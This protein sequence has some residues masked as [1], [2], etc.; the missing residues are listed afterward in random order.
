MLR[1]KRK[2]T[3]FV[4]AGH[5]DEIDK[6]DELLKLTRDAKTVR[7]QLEPT[8]IK[9]LSSLCRLTV[10]E[11][12]DAVD[13]FINQETDSW[14]ELRMIDMIKGTEAAVIKMTMLKYLKEKHNIKDTDYQGTD[15]TMSPRF[16]SNGE[17]VGDVIVL[18]LMML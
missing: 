5:Q 15:L 16:D 4:L 17:I 2:K 10:D 9:E 13:N 6:Q 1:E 7:V 18:T 11:F 8:R 14:E 12:V 3:N